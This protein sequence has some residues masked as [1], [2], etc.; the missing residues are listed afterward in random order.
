MALISGG[1]G[2]RGVRTGTQ[3]HGARKP[4]PPKKKKSDTGYRP[5]PKRPISPP[6]SIPQSRPGPTA[7][8][9]RT[10]TVS[11]PAP[12][13]PSESQFLGQDVG[14]QQALREFALNLEQFQA[15]RARQEAQA[16]QQFELS[17]STAQEQRER[18]L[19]DIEA[20]FASRGVLHSGLYGS[21]LGEY[22]QDFNTLMQG[23]QTQYDDFLRQLADAQS[24]LEEQQRL[25]SER[26][27][28]EALARRA[29]R[30]GL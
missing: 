24:Q 9:G 3:E 1:G 26:A 17:Q 25:E 18:D 19:R 22:E 8:G 5:P 14:Y 4:T 15:D 27:R 7:G 23:Y 20:D 12:P 16:Q 10:P 11:K 13:P 28:Q 21:R 6:R 2:S 30:Y 29:T